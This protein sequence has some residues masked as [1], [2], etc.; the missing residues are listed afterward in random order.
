M[1][2]RDIYEHSVSLKL[3]LRLGLRVADVATGCS[4][5]VLDDA[6]S[7]FGL[8]A[9]RGIVVP[10]G[11][12]LAE[13]NRPI[14]VDLR[15]KRF[16]LALGRVVDKKGFDLLIDA[17]A[18]IADRHADVGLVIGGDGP[19]R[20]GLQAKVAALG[21]QD[22]IILPG[23]FD[24]GNVR[25]ATANAE[26]FV[27]PSRLEPF[28]IVVLE[29]MAAGSPVVVTARG[30]AGE[31]VRN[32]IE[33]LVVDPFETHTLAEAM[34]GLLVDPVRRADYVAAAT[35]RVR[36]YDWPII[37]QHYLELYYTACSG[38]RGR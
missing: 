21:L 10:N 25:W 35:K 19:A 1:D 27:L 5:F 33:G 32:G 28:G 31:I 24:R 15:F 30:G 37:T 22:R 17:F 3:G 16:V 8:A 14:P 2:D 9:G 18:L 23:R 12:E 11:V 7:R 13:V 20:I 29:A 26:L 36:E 38:A 34:H 4:Q 6:V